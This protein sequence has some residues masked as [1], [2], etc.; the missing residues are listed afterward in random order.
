M[1]IEEPLFQSYACCML[2]AAK[3]YPTSKAAFIR[4]IHL[5]YVTVVLNFDH[6]GL[7]LVRV[8]R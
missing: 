3:N 1:F 4:C 2:H 7:C 5:D 8:Y 6:E